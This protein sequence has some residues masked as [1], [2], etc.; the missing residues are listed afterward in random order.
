MHTVILDTDFLLQ[1]LRWK[2]DIR[3]ELFRILDVTF[4]IA[5]LDKTLDELSGKQDKQLA[6]AFANQLTV[7]STSR[8]KPVDDLLLGLKY[9]EPIL[10]ATQDKDLKEKL[11]KS[12]IPV[13]TIRKQ[14]HLELS[15]HVL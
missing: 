8:D 11:K 1:A 9:S 6:T 10:V 3:E 2:I 7:I 13:I 12:N 15:N 5:I 14:S 4:D